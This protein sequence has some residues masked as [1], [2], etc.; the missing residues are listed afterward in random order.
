MSD[1]SRP[2][3]PG[4]P[5]PLTGIRILD[6]TRLLPGGVLTALLGDLGADVIKIEEPV[7][8][9]YMR[10][11]EPRTG[12]ESA[13][14]WIVGRNKRSVGVD[15]KSPEGVELFLSLA[16]HA[17]VVIEGFRPGVVDRLGVGFEAVRARNP[18]IVYASLTGYGSDGP[19]RDAAGHD[20]NYISYAGVLGM[21]GPPG[22][23]VCPPGVQV[24]DLGGATILGIGLL[25]ALHGATTSGQGSHVEVA[26]YDAALAWTSIHAGEFWA[27][28]HVPDPGRMLLNGRYPCYNVYR[29]AD[30]RFL[31]LGAVEQK[32]WENFCSV[33]ERPD[34]VDRRADESARDEV[35]AVIATRSR[36]EWMALLEKAEACVA[37]V[38]DLG[39]A[40]A[41]PMARAR[42][43]VRDAQLE[44]GGQETA[45]T[46]GTAVRIDG[47]TRPTGTPPPA[48]GAD[49]RTIARE[50]G[51]T[52]DQIDLLMA[53]GVL[54][55]EAGR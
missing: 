26:M 18:R 9:D 13:A 4:S 32:F 47:R 37:P 39:E 55:A 23:P 28:G 30:G 17:D 36:D 6:L 54:R 10:W 19:M 24:G 46:L 52:D 21:T 29:C 35:A 2:L 22:G 16:E 12:A 45:L 49:T 41:H 34:L 8:G 25:A 15:L 31:S 44:P 27:S 48:L 33:V 5:G 40:L 20:I 53:R 7:L 50:A 14:S 1:D 42:H 51:L 3:P 43:M 11:E 38:L